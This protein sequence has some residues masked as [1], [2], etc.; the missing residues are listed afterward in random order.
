ML[1]PRAPFLLLMCTTHVTT[2]RC[3]LSLIHDLVIM[4]GLTPMHQNTGHRI[5]SEYKGVFT[6]PEYIHMEK[7]HIS[8]E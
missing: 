7:N 1:S 3:P 5:Y 8:I 2:V 4:D 6:S